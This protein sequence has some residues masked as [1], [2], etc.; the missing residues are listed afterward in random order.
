MDGR[1]G[2]QISSCL[3]RGVFIDARSPTRD[4]RLARAADVRRKLVY[5]ASAFQRKCAQVLA[6]AIV[7]FGKPGR[8]DNYSITILCLIGFDMILIKE[9]GRE[10]C[11]GCN[12]DPP[13]CGPR[14]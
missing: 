8:G 7:E 9:G 6:D 1:S 13:C 3:P 10:W 4:S 12:C 5:L 11:V 14:V 2:A